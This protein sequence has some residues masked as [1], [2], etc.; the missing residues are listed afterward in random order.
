[1]QETM[2]EN[3]LLTELR[4][5]PVRMDR[6]EIKV[7]KIEDELKTLSNTITRLANDVHHLVKGKDRQDV[8]KDR[9]LIAAFTVSLTLVAGFI[10]S[11][12]L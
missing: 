1:M 3:Q 7:G 10:F 5:L 8:L 4:G 2:F 12:Y 9:I 6:L 11:T